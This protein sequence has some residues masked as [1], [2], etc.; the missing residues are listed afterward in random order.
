[1]LLNR[2]V[3]R[4]RLHH[5]NHKWSHLLFLT[6][7]LVLSTGVATAKTDRALFQAAT[8]LIAQIAKQDRCAQENTDARRYH[9]ADI[10]GDGALDGIVLFAIEGAGCGNNYGFHMAVFYKQGNEYRLV[11]YRLVG[12]KWSRG[13]DFDRVD[14]RDGQIILNTLEYREGGPRPDP[15]CCPSLKRKARYEVKDGKLVEIKSSQKPSADVKQPT[16]V[17]P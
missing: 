14:F 6:T 3:K 13:V 4:Y 10:D 12:G 2:A 16:G 11:D 8:T 15:A 5:V 1:M 7:L 9:H 17:E